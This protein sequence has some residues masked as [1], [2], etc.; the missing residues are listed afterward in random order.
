MLSGYQPT[1][2]LSDGQACVTSRVCVGKG[3]PGRNARATVGATPN[4]SRAKAQ[5]T[6]APLLG[7]PS[8]SSVEIPRPHLCPVAIAHGIAGDGKREVQSHYVFAEGSA[9]QECHGYGWG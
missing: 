6:V 8:T 9:G 3:L 1:G 2:W 5:A 4:T 7:P